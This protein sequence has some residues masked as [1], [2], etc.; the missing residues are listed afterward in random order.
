MTFIFFCQPL[1][2]ECL[3]ARMGEMS[4]MGEMGEMGVFEAVQTM[5]RV[6]CGRL[7]DSRDP[8]ILGLTT[9]LALQARSDQTSTHQ[10]RIELGQITNV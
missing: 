9:H 4:E 7:A 5:T 2:G 10:R 3:M 6:G 8:R 1:L